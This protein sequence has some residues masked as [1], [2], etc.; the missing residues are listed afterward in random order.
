[1]AAQ[2]DSQVKAAAA[3]A[4]ARQLIAERIS[5]LAPGVENDD[6]AQVVLHLAEAYAHLAMEPPR[7][8]AG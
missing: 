5:K 8:R 2:T 3:A 1:M 4:R 7:S 6:L